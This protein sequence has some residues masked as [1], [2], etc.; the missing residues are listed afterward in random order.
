[1]VV[2]SFSKLPQEIDSIRSI[3]CSN[4]YP[5]NL[6]NLRI[7]RKIEEFKIP[8][9]KGQENVQFTLNLHGWAIFLRNLK[10]NAK[11]LKLG[12]KRHIPKVIRNQ[13]QPDR[14]LSQFNPTSTLAIEHFRNNDKSA[15]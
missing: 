14:D 8:P 13:T 10:S 5:E 2:C 11:L 15:S 4:G 7:K 6:I 12:I 9:K 3:L 1:M